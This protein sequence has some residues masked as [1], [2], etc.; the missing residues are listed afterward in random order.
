MTRF[1]QYVGA[2]VTLYFA[3]AATANAAQAPLGVPDASGQS[4][5][6][7]T[8]R[9]EFRLPSEF[10]RAKTVNGNTTSG[11]YERTVKLD[12][13]V[14]CTISIGASARIQ[15]KRPVVDDG[16]F[17][18]IHGIFRVTQKGRKGALRWYLGPSGDER[19]AAGVT[20][21]PARLRSATR[22]YALFS[23]K[24]TNNAGG[25][26]QAAACVEEQKQSN[27]ALKTAVRTAHIVKKD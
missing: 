26:P 3:A 11:S 14:L 22:R 6:S 5:A 12:D 23:F 2:A 7:K 1:M 21:P 8:E 20:R 10:E 13:G 15:R 17:G 9:V 25:T 27:H 16:L 24:L 19:L 18:T 4:R